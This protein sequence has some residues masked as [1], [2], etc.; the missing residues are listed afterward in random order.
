MNRTDHTANSPV[1]DLRSALVRLEQSPDELIS[2]DHEIDPRSELAG[3]YKRVGA[4]GT[5]MRPTRTG[6]AMMFENVKGYPGARVLVGLIP[7]I[8]WPDSRGTHRFKN[9]IHRMQTIL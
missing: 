1:I 5:V 6:P 7:T 8:V 3:V 9:V 2:T 4:G